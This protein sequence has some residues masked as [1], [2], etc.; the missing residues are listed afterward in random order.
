MTHHF[1]RQI[2]ALAV[3]AIVAIL[4][5]VVLLRFALLNS[6]ADNWTPVHLPIPASGLTVTADFRLTSRGRFD[7]QIVT[8]AKTIEKAALSREGP[9]VPMYATLTIAGPNGFQ[10]KQLITK[11]ELGEWGGDY[12]YYSAPSVL[13]PSAGD[14]RILLDVEQSPAFVRE[15]GGM[16]RLA[17]VAPSGYGLTYSVATIFAYLSFATALMSNVAL[18]RA[19][20]RA[21]E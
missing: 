3:C 16:F 2:R 13:L 18:I 12:N 21:V 7:P 20:L 15:R 14:Y 19:H 4:V 1:M 11:V 9:P 6:D 5:G 10:Y 8:I 17:R